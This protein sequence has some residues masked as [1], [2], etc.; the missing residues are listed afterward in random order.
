MRISFLIV[1]ILTALY[2][3]WLYVGPAVVGADKTLETAGHFLPVG[4]LFIAGTVAVVVEWKE[5]KRWRP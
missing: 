1:L 2:I 4:A 3:L 5:R